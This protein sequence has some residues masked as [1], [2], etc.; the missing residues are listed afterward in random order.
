MIMC[1]EVTRLAEHEPFA[2]LQQ[3]LIHIVYIVL[4]YPCFELKLTFLRHFFRCFL[5]AHLT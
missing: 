3:H 4:A 5:S 2:I 1:L